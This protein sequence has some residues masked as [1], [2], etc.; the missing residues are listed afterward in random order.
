M[1]HVARAQDIEYDVDQHPHACTIRAGSSIH[2]TMMKSI[3]PEY[4][5]RLALAPAM[6][7]VVGDL[8]ARGCVRYARQSLRRI[9]ASATATENR[10]SASK[11]PR[12]VHFWTEKD[13]PPQVH[14]QVTVKIGKGKMYFC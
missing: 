10:S 7:N 4:T 6:G 12:N 3:L 11:D 1:S 9:V 14:A 5:H 13:M 8:Y 2:M